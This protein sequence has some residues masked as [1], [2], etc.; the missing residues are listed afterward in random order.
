MTVPPYCVLHWLQHHGALASPMRLPGG[1]HISMRL[2]AS[3]GRML[4]SA[5][6]DL[7]PRPT[8]SDPRLSLR[9]VNR[10]RRI[11]HLSPLFPRPL[12]DSVTQELKN[13][14][15]DSA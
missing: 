2:I 12:K 13:F 3:D 5:C 7:Y 10:P 1:A 11:R 4:S 15:K 14:T 8:P 6:C 9:L